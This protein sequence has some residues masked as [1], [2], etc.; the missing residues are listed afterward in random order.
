MLPFFGKEE[1]GGGSPKKKNHFFFFKK[2]LNFFL[3]KGGKTFWEIW[4]PPLG[5]EKKKKP[6]APGDGGEPLIIHKIQGFCFEKGVFFMGFGRG[7]G[8]FFSFPQGFNFFLIK[9][10]HQ[11]FSLFSFFLVC[12]QTRYEIKKKG[13]RIKRWKNFNLSGD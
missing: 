12:G 2:K 1:K 11:N 10:K 8:G 7:A 6:A 5:I 4:G 9:K 3:P 13:L